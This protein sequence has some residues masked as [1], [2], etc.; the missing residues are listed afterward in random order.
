MPPITV[1]ITLDKEQPLGLKLDKKGLSVV[2]LKPKSPCEGALFVG[3]KFLKVNGK[4]VSDLAS[5][6]AAVKQGAGKPIDF[7]VERKDEAISGP[8]YIKT[9][10]KEV[11]LK[12][13]NDDKLGFSV[14]SDMT[15]K[16]VNERSLASGMLFPGD[17]I[18]HFDNKEVKSTK[19]LAAVWKL[20]KKE[21]GRSLTLT[22]MRT[23]K[24]TAV[25]TPPKS[26]LKSSVESSTRDR[27][28][29]DQTSPFNVDETTRADICVVLNEDAALGLRMKKD[30]IVQDVTAGS[31]ADGLFRVGDRIIRV[32]GLRFENLKE[33]NQYWEKNRK[34]TA[35][36]N[37]S[38]I[39]ALDGCGEKDKDTDAENKV[40]KAEIKTENVTKSEKPNEDESHATKKSPTIQVTIKLNENRKLGLRVSHSLH[41]DHIDKNSAAESVVKIGDVITHFNGIKVSNN[42]EFVSFLKDYT[43]SEPKL[44]IVRR[45]LVKE[46]LTLDVK[47]KEGEKMG[48][49]TTEHL[50]VVLI[51]EKSP[52]DGLF[53]VGDHIIHVN[54]IKVETN[55]RFAEIV[56]KCDS[57]NVRVGIIRERVKGD[58][59]EPEGDCAF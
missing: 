55:D 21:E 58:A 37:F 30:L 53:K 59:D 15:V 33:F 17:L 49:T 28:S 9:E 45:E 22:I 2:A 29:A 41:V 11:V 1:S 24:S 32:D 50:K 31:T 12:L 39:R 57:G 51:R 48:V 44:T 10:E 14:S 19:E 40:E 4:A 18:T 3:D 34:Q 8:D 13:R 23:K 6:Q 42:K 35:K 43:G 26:A 52:A 5:F 56:R 54:E 36:H 25:S 27:K 20:V 7:L 47:M 46:P 38:V 16:D